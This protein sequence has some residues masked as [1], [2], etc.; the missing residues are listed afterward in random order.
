[1]SL[2]LSSDDPG[3]LK[4]PFG[5]GMAEQGVGSS[6]SLCVMERRVYFWKVTEGAPGW[7]HISSVQ[8]YSILLAL[9]CA[10]DG[11]G[12]SDQEFSVELETVITA[13]ASNH[14]SYGSIAEIVDPGCYLICF[15]SDCQLE[16]IGPGIAIEGAADSVCNIVDFRCD[17]IHFF[18]V[19]KHRARDLG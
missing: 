3:H 4:R 1:M 2:F 8:R 12:L 18:Q 6:L 14:G 16:L 5:I 17:A 13:E 10:G 15:S 9:L 7:K 19:Q 11:K